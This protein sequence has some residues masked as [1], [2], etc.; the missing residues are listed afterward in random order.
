[1]AF[2]AVPPGMAAAM[3]R[4]RAEREALNSPDPVTRY[5]AKE[6]MQ[7]RAFAEFGAALASEA[8]RNAKA[9][10]RCEREAQRF[11]QEYYKNKLNKGI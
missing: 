3:E 4:E 5:R 1:M 7:N 9:A 8:K 6:R 2:A 11:E 10:E